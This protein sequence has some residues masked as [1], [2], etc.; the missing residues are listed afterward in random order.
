MLWALEMS[1]YVC[2]WGGRGVL[3][4]IVSAQRTRDAIFIF[5]GQPTIDS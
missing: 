5:H 1:V 3:E 2:V 4:V